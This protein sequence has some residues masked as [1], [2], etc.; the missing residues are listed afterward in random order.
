MAYI[1]CGRGTGQQGDDK[2]GFK[3]YLGEIHF[4]EREACQVGAVRFYESRIHPTFLRLP[5][6][7]FKR[8]SNVH[9]RQ[10]EIL[11]TLLNEL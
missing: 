10:V 6:L 3:K 2:D 9:S 11:T 5:T 1:K 4:C 8:Q 7:F